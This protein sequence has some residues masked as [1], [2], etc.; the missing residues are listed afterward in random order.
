V[1]A[2]AMAERSYS[3][4]YEVD[5]VPRTFVLPAGNTWTAKNSG[6][7]SYQSYTLRNA[8]AQS[9]NTVAAYLMQQMKPEMVIDYARQFGI[10]S[11]LEATP[12]LALG[13][14]GDVSVFDLT[15]AYGVF[16]NQG[17]WIEPMFITEI[18]DK[19]GKTLYRHVPPQKEV[20][21]EEKAYV[22]TYMLRGSTETPRGTARGLSKY[23]FFPGTEVA[24][25]TGT[26]QNYSDGWFMGYTKDLVTG[27][28]V[29]ADQRSI[30]F[31]DGNLGQGARM[32]MPAFGHFLERVY[33]D[34][35][36]EYTRGPFPKPLGELEMEL[37]CSKYHQ[38][39]GKRDSTHYVMP[40][41]PLSGQF[42]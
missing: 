12:A 6:G 10:T 5:D 33:A 31:R 39:G 28:W 32:A 35:S 3:P 37:D 15:G 2:T 4:C 17:R 27:V 34:P 25:K 38:G 26:T 30:H 11:K 9:L 7:Y 21:S 41:N 29:G 1:Y 13:G 16:A 14:G 18:K 20:L 24:A 40:T 23:T 42:D 19:T 8:L 36:L 22:M